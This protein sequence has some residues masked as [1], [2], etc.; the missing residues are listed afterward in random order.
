M[1]GLVLGWRYVHYFWR[2]LNSTPNAECEKVGDGYA[3]IR[4]Q[5]MPLSGGDKLG[6]YETLEPIGAGGM[7]E[8]YRA[9]DH[10]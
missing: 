7:G 6:P 10:A 4:A 1:A 9:R 2:T 3:V 5:T 8:V